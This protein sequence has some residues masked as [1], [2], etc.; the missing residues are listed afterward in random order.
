MM[1]LDLQQVIS[2]PIPTDVE[3]LHISKMLFLLLVSE[4][5]KN[6]PTEKCVNDVE[7]SEESADLYI[8]LEDE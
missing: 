8:E 7:G 4:E 6:V 2:L 5:D 3:S 1:T